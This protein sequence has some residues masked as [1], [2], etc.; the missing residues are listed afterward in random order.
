MIDEKISKYKRDQIPVIVDNNDNIIWLAP[1]KLSNEYKVI[2][3]TDKVLILKL[4]Y[5]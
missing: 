3:E 5:K 4:K 1:Y 2:E